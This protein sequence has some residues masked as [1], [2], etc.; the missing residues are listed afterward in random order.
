[1]I[2]PH[3][4]YEDEI[5]CD[6]LIPSM[7]KRTWAAQLEILS[8]VD[9]ACREN[10]MEY[11]AEWGTLLGAVRHAG[12]IPWD[13]DLDICMK[14]SDYNRFIENVHSLMSSD[15]SIVNYRSNR[16][17]KQML[18]RIVSSDHYRFDP[19]YMHKYSGFPIALGID[20]FPLD[21]LTGDDEYEKEREERANLVYDAVNEIAYFGTDPANI[22][23]HIKKIESRCNIKLDKKGDIL[24]QLRELLE[25]IF[26]EVEEKDAKYITLYPLWMNKHQYV[27]PVEAYRN[28]IRLPFENTTVPVPVFY[29]EILRKKYGSSYMTPVRSGGAHEYPY[30]E[31]H[32]N[33]LREHFGYEWP[34][35]KF[36]LADVKKCEAAAD[37]KGSGRAV[38][39]TYS[40]IA[41]ENMRKVVRRYIRQGYDVT[42]LPVT[43]Y[44]IAAD[45]TGITA[46]DEI[47]TD[48]HYLKGCEGAVVSHDPDIIN[49]RPDVIVTNYP[50]DEYNLITTVDK[51]FY[52]RNLKRCC[53]RLVYVPPFETRSIKEDDERA[54]KLMPLYVQTPA[55]VICDEIILSGKEMKARY[56]ECLSAFSGDGYREIWD[57]KI[58]VLEDEETADASDK[59]AI[60]G[61]KK[62]MFYAG[63][64]TFAQL[65][66]KAVEKIRRVF[67]TF[68]ANA[69]KVDVVYALHESVG[70]VLSDSLKKE[71][72]DITDAHKGSLCN[73]SLEMCTDCDAYYG[74]ESVYATAMME[75]KKPVMIMNADII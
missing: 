48:D 61:K 67:E 8:D 63:A 12:F 11:F 31:Q 40:P 19:E 15:H 54:V 20:I 13:D 69:D 73:L 21:F 10:G 35:Y 70:T 41:F 65:G 34:T 17:F 14:R 7:V 2:F 75:M 27:F 38:F 37:E 16:E 25:K 64:A 39:V 71:L 60:S 32:V 4:F 52:S 28:S 62:I 42:I 58:T 68:D 44:D 56:V 24:T 47:A 6:F 57:K 72:D 51:A 59:K 45:M 43:K 23:D 53:N 49:D 3:S 26:S 5:R 66:P 29:D 18:S 46:S 74:E 55:P 36:A 30:F 1:M 9:R 33:I 22:S 50:Y